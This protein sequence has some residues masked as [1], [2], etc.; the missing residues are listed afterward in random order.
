[1]DYDLLLKY[2]KEKQSQATIA[3]IKVPIEDASRF[4]IVNTDENMKIVQFEEKPKQPK[5]N[6]ASMGIYVFD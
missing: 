2:H 5:S 4:G 6:T 1:M 3:V